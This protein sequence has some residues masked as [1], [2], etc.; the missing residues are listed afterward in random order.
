MKEYP[1]GI[2]PYLQVPKYFAKCSAGCD[3]FLSR[4][5]KKNFIRFRKCSQFSVLCKLSQLDSVTLSN[6]LRSDQQEGTRVQ[7]LTQIQTLKS[8]PVQNPL[9]ALPRS[10]AADSSPSSS[11]SFFS[12]SCTYGRPINSLYISLLLLFLR[13]WFS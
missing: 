12:L 4:K 2:S 10:S 7:P 6:H 11:Q 9:A 8:I 3:A 1:C 5:K 13:V